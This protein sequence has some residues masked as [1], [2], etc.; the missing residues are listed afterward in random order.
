MVG[1]FL[2]NNNNK[3]LQSYDLLNNEIIRHSTRVEK[4]KLKPI[5]NIYLDD[6]RKYSIQ[7][8]ISELLSYHKIAFELVFIS[9]N[10][11]SINIESA[12][13]SDLL[14]MLEVILYDKGT[15]LYKVDVYWHEDRKKGHVM[16]DILLD[17]TAC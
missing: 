13:F 15:E 10:K 6:E 7:K 9:G 16:A 11:L 1:F 5:C 3:L 17:I 12:M 8:K 4:F 2:D 14:D